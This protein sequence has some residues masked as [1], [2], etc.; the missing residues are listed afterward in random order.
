MASSFVQI[1]ASMEL[2]TEGEATKS[3]LET[4]VE[5]TSAKASSSTSNGKAKATSSAAALGA[6]N[7]NHEE[8]S[9]MDLMGSI[10]KKLVITPAG[11]IGARR[12]RTYSITAPAA[13]RGPAEYLQGL[14][15]NY[16]EEEEEVVM[17][18]G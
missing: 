18:E 12:P 6:S 10:T 2:P 4:A 5:G 16:G 3:A 14:G 9:V 8:R 7:N 15:R 11:D 13:S 17:M 1:L